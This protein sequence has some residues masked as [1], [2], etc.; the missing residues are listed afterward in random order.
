MYFYYKG[1]FGSNEIIENNATKEKEAFE[2]F[3]SNFEYLELLSAEGNS[4]AS[5]ILS[6][7]YDEGVHYKQSKSKAIALLEKPFNANCAFCLNYLGFLYQGEK[8]LEGRNAL[9]HAYALGSLS[10]K[11]NLIHVYT[12]DKPNVLAEEL[13]NLADKE[14]YYLANYE[15]AEFFEAKIKFMEEKITEEIFISDNNLK[16]NENN[17][18]NFTSKI[19]SNNNKASYNN[20][21]KSLEIN[22]YNYN[23]N[24]IVTNLKLEIEKNILLK[25]NS[26]FIKAVFY[27]TKAAEQGL[28]TSVAK[29]SKLHLESLKNSSFRNLKSGAFYLHQAKRKLDLLDYL[30]I[31]KNSTE[32]MQ[33][34]L[35]DES[36]KEN[37]PANESVKYVNNLNALRSFFNVNF[38]ENIGKSSE[39]ENVKS[40]Q[41]FF[42]F[43][44]KNDLIFMDEK[45]IEQNKTHSGDSINVGLGVDSDADKIALIEEFENYLIKN[46]ENNEKIKSLF[47]NRK[48]QLQKK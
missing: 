4:D 38:K 28:K 5:L 40:F 33:I 20:I 37:N 35:P 30:K 17:C 2:S 16:L 18:D 47:L 44:I 48:K 41:N 46:C 39:K 13:R 26:N 7:C 27:Y 32:L 22:N 45:E 36:L 14:D 10:A 23:N 31:I 3:S 21:N 25:N 42:N 11:Y 43:L 1:I 12:A 9:E 24:A 15:I 29:L 34:F 19:I 6:I 8:P